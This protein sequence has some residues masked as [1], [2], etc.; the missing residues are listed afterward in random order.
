[1]CN[2][3]K[4]HRYKQIFGTIDNLATKNIDI[5]DCSQKNNTLHI[6]LKHYLKQP[7]IS[8]ETDVSKHWASLKNTFPS[9]YVLVW[10]YGSA[11]ATSVPAERIFS[12]GRIK[13]DRNR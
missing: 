12:A 4:G 10:Q 1:M 5:I 9:L 11:I 7:V 6:E 13:S 2:W 3:T 8:R